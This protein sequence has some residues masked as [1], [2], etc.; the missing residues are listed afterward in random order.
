VGR[1][2][3]RD[4]IL[5]TLTAADSIGVRALI[6]HA[7]DPSAVAFYARHG[8]EASPTDAVHRVLLLKDIRASLGD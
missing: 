6:L 3:L 1:G 5:R 8:F 7:R 4:A 2:L